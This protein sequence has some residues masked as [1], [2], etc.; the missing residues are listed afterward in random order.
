MIILHF[1]VL[2]F[3]LFCVAGNIT[4]EGDLAGSPRINVGL[5][6]FGNHAFQLG[7]NYRCQY[8]NGASCDQDERMEKEKKPH[9]GILYF[10]DLQYWRLPYTHR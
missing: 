3:G 6:L 4:L 7:R 8:V 10:P 9:Y 5:L 2:L 1:I